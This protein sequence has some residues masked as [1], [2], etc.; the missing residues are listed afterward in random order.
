MTTTTEA[1]IRA[2]GLEEGEDGE[3]YVELIPAEENAEK[4]GVFQQFMEDPTTMPSTIAQQ[5]FSIVPGIFG[6]IAGFVLATRLADTPKVRTKGVLIASG[7]VALLT[8]GSI[9]LIVEAEKPQMQP[10]EEE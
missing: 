4:K 10:D 3:E 5:I 8:F 6:G 2:A 1:L 7:L 9:F